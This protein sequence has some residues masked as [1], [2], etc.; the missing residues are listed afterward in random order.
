M[1]NVEY[2]LEIETS[3]YIAIVSRQGF[4]KEKLILTTKL[5]H[6]LSGFDDKL[7]GHFKNK[8]SFG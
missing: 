4:R 6:K 7:V 8:A 3:L 2:K 1:L 5:V